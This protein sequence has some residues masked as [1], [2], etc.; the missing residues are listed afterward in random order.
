MSEIIA[1]LYEFGSLYK[2]PYS[3]ALFDGIGYTYLGI[4]MLATSIITMLAFYYVWNPTFGRWFHWIGMTGV[5][6]IVA[7]AFSYGVLSEELVSYLDNSNHPDAEFFIAQ[8][9]LL[10]AVYTFILSVIVSFPLRVKST[11]NKA[12][13]FALKLR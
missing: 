4:I 8:T 12:N 1:P 3:T 7:F 5:A 9:S 6:A 13:P 11:N 10:T 2:D